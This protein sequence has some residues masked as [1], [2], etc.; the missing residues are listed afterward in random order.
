[1]LALGVSR[2]RNMRNRIAI[3]GLFVILLLAVQ[4]AFADSVNYF[5]SGTYLNQPPDA[6]GSGTP[7]TPLTTPGNT[8]SFSFSV[9]LPVILSA[10][11][12]SICSPP[13][14]FTTIVPISYSSGSV[15]V[16]VPG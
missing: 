11:V 13:G 5:S 3:L 12:P 6:H 8:L 4:S 7:T 1:M 16:T 2:E 15:S 10:N 14:C 9:S